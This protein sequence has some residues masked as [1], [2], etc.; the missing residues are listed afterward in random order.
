MKTVPFIV[1]FVKDTELGGFT[2]YSE[3]FPDVIAEG[4][5]QKDA[6]QNLTTAI[7]ASF[8]RRKMDKPHTPGI[9]SREYKLQFGSI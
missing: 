1:Y 6:V 7:A 3:Q 5:T 9:E 2:A 4:T 8:S